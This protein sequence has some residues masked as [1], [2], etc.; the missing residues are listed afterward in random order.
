MR[1]VLMLMVA[2]LMASGCTQP[3]Q[4][5]Q[6]AHGTWPDDNESGGYLDVVIESLLT[7]PGEGWHCGS[8]KLNSSLA[9]R[10][11]INTAVEAARQAGFSFMGM[12][13]DPSWED[14]DLHL[15]SCER[16]TREGSLCI[17]GLVVGSCEGWLVAIGVRERIE[18]NQS[19]E[20][21]IDSIHENDGVAYITHPMQEGNCTEWRRW[22]ISTWDGLAVTSPMT[23]TRQDDDEALE[24]W[25]TLLN[26]GHH[27][28]A[29]GEVDIKPFTSTYS[30]TDMLDSSYQCL[31]I[32]DNLTEDSVREALL[33]GRFYVTNGP[34]LN[35]AVNGHG[36]GEEVNASYGNYVNISLDVSS[37]AAFSRVRIIKNGVVIQEIGKSLNR[38]SVNM[39]SIV[40]RD[41]WFSAD[42]WGGDYTA[43]YH[44]FVHAIS[45]PVWIRVVEGA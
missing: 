15:E 26:N 31:Y 45:N 22:D 9:G 19:L 1:L 44:D 3:G 20:G 32:E 6:D 11:G 25:H 7:A 17:P 5:G 37:A 27:V 18:T 4:P 29:F 13:I 14:A 38:Y 21:M 23:Q 12:I 28:S 10:E 34:V 39:A 33:S 40:A 30:L 35:F 41:T 24:K 43:E 36:P 2:V 8:F 16:A 42:V